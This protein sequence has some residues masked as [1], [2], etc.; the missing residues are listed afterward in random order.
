MIKI[1]TALIADAWGELL[2]MCGEH[3]LGYRE[4]D[5]KRDHDNVVFGVARRYVCRRCGK[6]LHEHLDVWQ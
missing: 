3:D 2:C 1:I 5:L 6:V 4:D